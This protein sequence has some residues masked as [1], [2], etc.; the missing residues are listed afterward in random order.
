MWG[1]TEE[2]ERGRENPIWSHRSGNL[3]SPLL[4]LLR[5]PHLIPDPY[6]ESFF[7]PSSSS[8]LLLIRRRPNISSKLILYIYL[9]SNTFPDTVFERSRIRH[10][11]ET[12]FC[13]LRVSPTGLD[14]GQ[15]NPGSVRH[16]QNKNTKIPRP[17]VFM[18]PTCIKKVCWHKKSK[19]SIFFY[20]PTPPP[21][22]SPPLPLGSDFTHPTMTA[23]A[24]EAH[25]SVHRCLSRFH[26]RDQKVLEKRETRPTASPVL[27]CEMPTCPKNLNN[28]DR[29]KKSE[30][31][32]MTLE[33]RNKKKFLWPRALTSLS[34]IS[35]HDRQLI[36]FS[37][38]SYLSLVP[39]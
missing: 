3:F 6:L 22:Q 31:G 20:L 5:R 1:E 34:H 11:T 12:K 10:Q 15:K 26:E 21:P 28:F 30:I 19:Q 38:L 36:S 35:W 7:L 25:Q 14:T 4:L 32:Q 17:V 37:P 8:L 27:G 13:F 29:G 16:I 2:E 9:C 33:R 24:A 18:A 23:A 39:R